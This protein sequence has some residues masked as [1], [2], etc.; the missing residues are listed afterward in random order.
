[1]QLKQALLFSSQDKAH[2]IIAGYQVRVRTW[3]EEYTPLFNFEV[4]C[5]RD[6]Y[7]L[8]IARKVNGT[9]QEPHVQH[10]GYGEAFFTWMN[11]EALPLSP[12]TALN[13]D[14]WRPDEDEPIE[15]K[16]A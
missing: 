16:T 8:T 14:N 7:E 5:Y 9:W 15:E 3:Q 11:T 10:I 13:F 12:S 2:A 4:P 1:M 6:A